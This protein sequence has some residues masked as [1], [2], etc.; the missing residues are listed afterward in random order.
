MLVSSDVTFTINLLSE[1]MTFAVEDSIEKKIYPCIKF[2]TVQMLEKVQKLSSCLSFR[3]KFL[4]SKL[5][6]F[7]H[8]FSIQKVY[9][10]RGDSD[11]QVISLGPC[12]KLLVVR[13]FQ[14]LPVNM[15][16]FDLQNN[17]SASLQSDFLK[18]ALN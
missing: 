7:L 4:Q 3:L 1:S 8:H 10:S 11:W 9:Y 14:K 12:N 6:E 5:L 16:C 15:N 2:L 17:V 13:A 18:R